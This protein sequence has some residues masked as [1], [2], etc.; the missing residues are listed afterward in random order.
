MVE[1]HKLWM[2]NTHA[3]ASTEPKQ[4]RARPKAQT[5]QKA[6][7]PRQRLRHGAVA[8]AGGREPR[9]GV[10]EQRVAAQDV[11][12]HALRVK[13]DVGQHREDRRL[14]VRVRLGRRDAARV[15][16]AQPRADALELEGHEVLQVGDGR[17]LAADACFEVF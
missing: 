5:R 6:H 2:Q 11:V 9:L 17:G 13:V 15:R 10:R 14:D 16:V 7:A 3:A 4:A 1:A 8:V 12:A